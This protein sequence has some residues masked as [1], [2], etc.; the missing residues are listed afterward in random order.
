MT[1]SLAELEACVA[2]AVA[3]GDMQSAARLS[4]KASV[5]FESSGLPERATLHA[6]GAVLFYITCEEYD[7][8]FQAGSRFLQLRSQWP[9]AGFSSPR[10]QEVFIEGLLS[11]CARIAKRLATGSPNIG[12]D[13]LRDVASPHCDIQK[14]RTEAFRWIDFTREVVAETQNCEYVA[15]LNFASAVARFSVSDPE[16][17]LADGLAALPF[18]IGDS[19][20]SMLVALVEIIVHADLACGKPDAALTVVKDALAALPV[21]SDPLYK[22][23][24]MN[25]QVVAMMNTP[26]LSEAVAIAEEALGVA[27]DIPGP[28]AA[29]TLGSLRTSLSD[30]YIQQGQIEKAIKLDLDALRTAKALHE[31]HPEAIATSSLGVHCG[32][33]SRRWGS[34]IPSAELDALLQQV[35][36]LCFPGSARNETARDASELGR[37]LL[38]KALAVLTRLGDL[39]SAGRAAANLTNFTKNATSESIVRSLIE[40]LR[41]IRANGGRTRDEMVPLANLGKAYLA[42]GRRDAAWT[43]LKRSLAIAEDIHDFEWAGDAANDLAWICLRGGD[44]D[45]AIRWFRQAVEYLDK[46]RRALSANE[47]ARTAFARSDPRPYEPL[48]EL[49][50]ARGELAT[51]FGIAQRGKSRALLEL[52]GHKLRDDSQSLTSVDNPCSFE[53]VVAS[54]A[55]LERSVI[56]LDYFFA[57]DQLLLFVARPDWVSPHVFH[58]NITRAQVQR[59]CDEMSREVIRFQ[60]EGLQTWSEAA[61]PLIA[62]AVHLLRADDLILFAPHGVLHNLALHALSIDG[63]PLIQSHPVAYL[64]SSSILKL[65]LRTPWSSMPPKSC[66]AIGVDF[67]IEAERVAALFDTA[68]VLRAPLSLSQLRAACVG[69]DV[70]H[71]SCHGY[72]DPTQPRNS[73]LVLVHPDGDAT[74]SPEVVTIDDL[75]KFDLRCQ[76]VCLSACSSGAARVQLGDEQIGIVRS[77]LLAGAPKVVSTLWPVDAFAAELF[78]DHFYKALRGQTGRPLAAAYAIQQAVAELRA[79]PRFASSY[80]WAPYILSGRPI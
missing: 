71:F 20:I 14:L 18:F 60:G 68:E 33:L 56:L 73:G 34:D 17:A 69:R 9:L 4:R 11:C 3:S 24:L 80:H 2:A 65:T 61:G 29:Y 59:W 32:M 67:E 58:L 6:Q 76:L 72:F 43:C 77:F 38:E 1:S 39:K 8:A 26:R 75:M 15:R 42:M 36:Q 25:S 57:A 30:L 74:V 13:L 50:L 5:E 41:N 63:V 27:S 21:D 48:T 55:S 35:E 12:P 66:C 40:A 37:E 47:A 79:E 52:W 16:G 49:L 78:F 51:A 7:L 54:L 22:L 23:Q 44:E 70:Y 28:F 64:P 46:R 45:E 10:A 19:D 53:E 62:P 31:P